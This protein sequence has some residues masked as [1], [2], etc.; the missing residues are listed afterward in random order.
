MEILDEAAFYAR[1][2]VAAG[3]DQAGSAF[4]RKPNHPQSNL[5]AGTKRWREFR[6]QLAGSSASFPIK[7]SGNPIAVLTVYRA[8]INGFDDESVGLLDV[9]FGY[10]AM[11]PLPFPAQPERKRLEG[12]SLPSIW[13]GS[14]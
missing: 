10:A 6:T 9:V 5:R 2:D 14:C 11:Q 8:D 4:S 3:A 7:D 13:A 1:L 12:P